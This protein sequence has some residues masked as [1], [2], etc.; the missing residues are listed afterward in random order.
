MDF[1]VQVVGVA[2]PWTGAGDRLGIWCGWVMVGASALV[3]LLGW[4]APLGFAPLVALMGFLCLPAFRIADEDRPVLIVLLGGLI[5]AAVSTTWSP[6]HSAG[7][8]HS[9][10]LQITLGLPLF[11]S[12]VCGARRARP[13]LN[14]LALKVLAIG[15]GLFGA[16]LLVERA[17]GAGVYRWLHETYYG[18]I[19]IDL[20]PVEIAHST[21]VLALLWPAVLV[22]GLKRRWEVAL[23]AV[24]VAGMVVAAHAFQAD[25]PVLA[26]PLSAIAMLVIWRWPTAGPRLMAAGAAAASFLM[27]AAIWAVRASGH[28]AQLEQQVQ[29]SWAARMRYWSHTIDWIGQHPL[30]GWGLDASRA[31]GPGIV[32]HPHNGALQVWLELGFVGAVTAAAFWRLSIVRLSRDAPDL[33]MTGVAGSTVVFL[34]F[35]WVNFGLWQQWWI[36]LGCLVPV[37]AAML[38]HRRD[39][40]EVELATADPRPAR[41]A[42][43]LKSR[44]IPAAA[45]FETCD[46]HNLTAMTVGWR[47]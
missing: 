32:L 3:P 8:G 14:A 1:R 12:A 22:G 39:T 38:S 37:I 34:L 23:L 28:Y 13:R 35:A 31:M 45:E 33:Q 11:W 42:S 36:A 26:L 19:R 9:V 17:T 16:I 2:R 6:F 29:P 21:F 20:P 30:R 41:R 43:T 7:V 18:P 5:W 27:P 40:P 24:A 46:G 47:G 25:A 44:E 15:L 10:I 4:L